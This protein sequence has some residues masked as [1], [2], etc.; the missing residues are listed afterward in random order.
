MRVRMIGRAGLV[1]L[2]LAASALVACSSDAGGDAVASSSSVT[3]GTSAGTSTGEPTT[4]TSADATSTTTTATTIESAITSTST[5]STSATTSTTVP[6]RAPRPSEGCGTTPAVTG[7]AADPPGDVP[8]TFDAGGTERTYRLGIPAGYDPD[9]PAPLALNLHGSGSNAFQASVYSDLPAR[10]SER[11]VIT[12]TP[13][14]IGGRWDLGPT[15]AD[16]AFLVALVTDVAAHYCVDLAR[17]HA[18]GMSL[19]AWRAGAT[20]CQHPDLFASA[21]LVTVEVWPTG[22]PPMSVIAFH[23]TADPVVPYGEGADPGVEV[24][25]PNAGLSGARDNFADW[26]I[27]GGCDGGYDDEQLGDDVD[28]WTAT[29]CPAGIDV[30]LYTIHGGEHTWPGADVSIGATTQTIDATDL[31]LDVITA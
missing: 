2:L 3:A 25:G 18:V 7:P 22:C 10:A 14:A 23:G 12:V 27:G 13:D 11:G 4:S 15:D 6:A 21:V 1:G 9:V 29:G 24:A 28:H 31:A 8:L 19:G 17:V 30:E 16:D 5:T 26:A 20:A